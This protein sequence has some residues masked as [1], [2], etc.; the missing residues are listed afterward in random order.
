MAWRVHI[1]EHSSSSSSIHCVEHCTCNVMKHFQRPYKGVTNHNLTLIYKIN[2]WLKSL[3]K[4]LGFLECNKREGACVSGCLPKLVPVAW[5]W[6]IPFS[7]LSIHVPVHI[8]FKCCYWT[9]L[10]HF[11]WQQISYTRYPA[12]K[13][14]P[15]ISL[16]SLWTSSTPSKKTVVIYPISAHDDFISLYKFTFISLYKFTP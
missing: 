9:C 4:E 12:W 14:A 16:P 13:P 6:I 2:G 10:C 3:V 7:T 5:F 15:R 11:L 1:S 8:Y